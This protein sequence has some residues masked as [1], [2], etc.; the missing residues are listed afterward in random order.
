MKKYW[1]A[2]WGLVFLGLVA[3]GVAA[4]IHVSAQSFVRIAIG[5]VSF[6]WLLIITTV[7]WNL[8]FRA[9]QVRHA[10]GD[11]RAREIPVD[12]SRDA[13]VGRLQGRLLRLA[14][15][16]HVLSAAV[17]AAVTFL[18]GHVLGYYIAGFFLLSTL[19][20]PAGAYF[21]YLRAR[22]ATL[23]KETTFP[24]DDVVEL[25]RQLTTLE[26]NMKTFRDTAT[27]ALERAFREIDGLRADQRGEAARLRD[28]VR[29]AREAA[30]AQHATALLRHQGVEQ[31]V[32]AMTD[33]FDRSLD[34]LS[35][36]QELVT[37]LRA[38]LRLVKT[39]AAG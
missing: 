2:F 14:V 10:I 16:G 7:P 12:A 30:E 19:F 35:D 17:T 8:Y 9:R 15:A 6:Y 25:K 4:L 22:I 21:A 28:D 38:F 23:L 3:M 27:E 18:S 5:A 20:R 34:G 1:Q 31:R 32:A 11:S 13:E 33:H 37:G 36:Q 39:E 26:A 24:P 29:L